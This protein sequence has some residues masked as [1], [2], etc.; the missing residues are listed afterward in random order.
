ML[1]EVPFIASKI[2]KAEKRWGLTSKKK[3]RESDC[4]C[5][6]VC[7]HTLRFLAFFFLCFLSMFYVCTQQSIR[8]VSSHIQGCQSFLGKNI[9]NRK[10]T[11][12][13][14]KIYQIATKYTN[15][16]QNI[17]NGHKIYQHRPLQDSQKLTQSG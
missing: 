3:R 5:C 8:S 9:P 6:C 15:L 4:L 16:L 13:Y 14:Y 11:Q 17:P 7:I 10:K 1:S 2:A 12:N